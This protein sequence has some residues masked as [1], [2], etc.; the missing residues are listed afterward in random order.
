M[1]RALLAA[2]LT[3]AL[4]SCSRAFPDGFLFGASL[5]GF[6]AD[7]GCPTL[8]ADQCEDRRSDWYQL[9]TSEAELGDLKPNVTFEPLANG[10]GFWELYAQ[11]FDRAK[12][13]LGLGGVRLSIEWSRVFPEPTDGLEGPALAAAASPAA[14]A[15]YHA[16]LRA[17]RARGLTP[18]VTLNHYT[19]PVWIHDGVACHKDLA[20]C[21][22]RGW[23]DRERLHREIVKFTAF[24]AKEFGP[25]VDLWVTLNEPF[26]VVLPGYLLPSKD[27]VNPP[28]L[29][30]RFAEA[31]AVMVAMIEAH[32]KMYDAVKAHDTADLDGDGVAAQ[33]GLVYPLT[34]A[35]PKDPSSR[36]DQRAAQDVFTL[37]NTIF[38]DGVCKGLV[39]ADLDG[40][41]DSD[42]PRADLVGRMD[43][44]GVNYYTRVTVKGLGS[45]ALPA[46]SALTTF[47]PTDFSVWEDY[48]RGLYEMERYAAER[49]RL[50]LYVT[51]TGVDGAADPTAVA[52]WL[53]RTAEWSKRALREGVD[54]RGFFF[55]SLTDNYEWNHGMAMRFGL[56][57]VDSLDPKKPRT[58]RGAVADYRAITRARD[59]PADLVTKY[60]PE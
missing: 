12:D 23:L 1:T 56:Y 14:L 4:A 35:R 28:A 13:E 8:P 32:A 22:H 24:V 16:Q 39:D 29:S 48:P 21:A 15:G 59:V 6:Q 52:R 60:P 27:R 44:L 50:P 38:L 19:L 43:F 45:P 5:A 41:P 3:L 49:Y 26:A 20:T 42:E 17:L 57:A 33:V 31:R 9:V 37:Y 53:V 55:W 10:P 46:L 47:D 58:A 7:P 30:L 25:E 2:S 36:L 11:D 54:V 18:L 51:E 40:T 34:P